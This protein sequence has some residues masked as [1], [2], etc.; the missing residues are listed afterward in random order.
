MI[1][2][3]LSPKHSHPEILQLSSYKILGLFS[4]AGLSFFARVA[5]MWRVWFLKNSRVCGSR[6]ACCFRGF[7]GSIKFS[8]IKFISFF[9]NLSLFMPKPANLNPRLFSRVLIYAKLAGCGFLRVAGFRGFTH[10]STTLLVIFKRTEHSHPK[11][12]KEHVL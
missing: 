6:V 4:S 7:R 3:T 5:G 10:S 9:Q 12:S 8:L 2:R 1:Q 11:M